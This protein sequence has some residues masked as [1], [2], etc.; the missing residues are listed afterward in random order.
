MNGDSHESRLYGDEE[1]RRH[2]VVTR[3]YKVPPPPKPSSERAAAAASLLET[4]HS[5]LRDVKQVHN[6]APAQP[7]VVGA[8]PLPQRHLLDIL[9]D[10][11]HKADADSAENI[12]RRIST[13][14]IAQHV[15]YLKLLQKRVTAQLVGMVV[16]CLRGLPALL[17]LSNQ[18]AQEWTDLDSLVELEQAALRADLERL[19][20][21]DCAARYTFVPTFAHHWHEKTM[22]HCKNDVYRM[23]SQHYEPCV[24]IPYATDPRAKLPPRPPLVMQH[25][26]EVMHY[27]S[28]FV[29][30]E[31]TLFAPGMT[32][33]RDPV[34]TAN[35]STG[36]DA[37]S[38]TTAATTAAAIDEHYALRECI[39]TDSY[40]EQLMDTHDCEFA[41]S[42]STLLTLFDNDT[43]RFES[44]YGW[45]IPVKSRL[46]ML[47]DGSTKKR[48]YLDRSLP[49]R[50][51]PARQ[52]L[53]EA[54]TRKLLT[55]F[56][57]LL[58]LCRPV[59]TEN[60]N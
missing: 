52:K 32:L 53:S 14:T 43:K 35:T 34:I 50:Y 9:Y 5:S 17:A 23:Y 4:I 40:A 1:A 28:A 27:G 8:P 49:S 48:V 58:G 44:N 55:A 16:M 13:L 21:K 6:A 25:V 7:V 18:E 41:I 30:D 60:R 56:K 46:S 33:N 51:V 57:V 12:S 59:T 29:V 24:A 45:I 39:S 54:S 15:Q 42:S 19:A 37:S 22:V 2:V 11:K 36:E 20:R 38:S 3:D 10:R 47:K 31:E 26:K